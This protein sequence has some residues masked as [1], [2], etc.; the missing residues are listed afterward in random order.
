MNFS[1]L[2]EVAVVSFPCTL[3]CSPKVHD[4]GSFLQEIGYC[5]P[6]FGGTKVRSR[7]LVSPQSQFVLSTLLV[8]HGPNWLPAVRGT[9]GCGRTAVG[10]TVTP[11]RSHTTVSHTVSQVATF[12]ATGLPTGATLSHHAPH[13][14]T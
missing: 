2:R 9:G 14:R 3:P 5:M 11:T 4:V 6:V 13:E 12:R 1:S 7:F 8:G 10:L